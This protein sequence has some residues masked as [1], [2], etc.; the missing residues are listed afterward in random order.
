MRDTRQ[1]CAQ[2]T[3]CGTYSEHKYKKIN[4]GSTEM[5][6]TRHHALRTHNEVPTE[7]KYMSWDTQYAATMRS[8]YAEWYL[9]R[10]QINDPLRFAIHG[11]HELSTNHLETIK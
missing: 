9:Y 4:I 11:N 3:P 6:D 5:H 8:A 10:K 7:K 2:Q 1:S